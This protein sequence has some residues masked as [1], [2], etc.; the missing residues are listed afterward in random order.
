MIRQIHDIDKRL[1]RLRERLQSRENKPGLEAN[2][3]A[4]RAEIAR[5]EAHAYSEQNAMLENLDLTTAGEIGEAAE[6]VSEVEWVK[7]S[8]KAKRHRSAV[9]G[10]FITKQEAD[11]SPATAVSETVASRS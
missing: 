10:K 6:S 2:C 5:L 1:T 11:A 8:K 7:R 3:A 9:T 4:I